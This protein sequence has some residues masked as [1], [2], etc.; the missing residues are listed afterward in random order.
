MSGLSLFIKGYSLWLMLPAALLV[1][2]LI[3]RL[4]RR[5]TEGLL[6]AGARLRTLRAAAVTLMVLLLAQPIVNSVRLEHE[7]PVVIVLRDTSTSMTVKD[8]HEPVE[9]RVRNAVALGLLDKKLRDTSADDA[10][11][12]FTQA[13]A[14]AESASGNIRQ[15][16]QLLA[17]NAAN[18]AT[19]R[20]RIRGACTS[21]GEA[22]TELQRGA[23][24]LK[25]IP[26]APTAL[27][28]GAEAQAQAIEKLAKEAGEIEAEK[29]DSQAK[30][31]D[32]A[33]VLSAL[34]PEITKLAA[35][36]QRVQDAADRALAASNN[37][38]V[39]AALERLS[40]MDRSAVVSGMIDSKAA[41]EFGDRVKLVQYGFDTDLRELAA[42][43]TS[44]DS[45]A[46]TATPTDTDLATPLI[47]IAERH[48]QDSIAAVV[49]CTDGRHTSGPI[50]ED[51]ARL[52][53]AR[54]IIVHTLGVG[55]ESAP[56]DICI[57]RL[58]GTQSV[59]MDETIKLTAHVKVAGLKGQKCNL[60]LSRE[61]KTVQ[62]RELTLGDDGWLH[63]NFE[64][65]ADKPGPNVFTASIKPLTGEALT[66]N[67]S[68]E[69]IVDVAND[70]LKVLLAD[71]LPRWESRY[72]AS[73]LRRER[74]M[75]LD[76]RW[77]LSGENLG[78]K[79]KALPQDEKALEDYEIIILGDIPAERLSEADQKRLAAYVADR[80]GFLVLLAGPRSMPQSYLTG[81]IA[82]LL[83]IRQQ[84]PASMT[85]A[86]TSATASERVRV[87][88]DEAGA[89]HEITR[90][91]H[92][93]TLNEQLWT[94]LPELHWVARPAYAKPLATT[95]L[96]TDDA[97][98]DVVVA[99]Q[100]YG[101]GRVMYVGTDG[102][103][104]WRYKVA[105]RVHAFFWSQAM[106]WGTSNRLIG[107]PRLKVGCVR[108]QIRPGE[109]VEILAR[110]RDAQ[111]HIVAD[112]TV[113][114]DLGD[115]A[116][117][118]HV[119]LT[120]VPDSG[121]LYR[122]DLQNV[123]AGVHNIV[124][125]VDA[126][127]FDGIQQEIQVIARDLAGQ[128]GIE[129]SRDSARLAAMAKAGGGRYMDILDAPELF[130]QLAGQGKERSVEK[131]YEIWSS[132]PILMLIVGLLAMEWIM[133]KRLGLA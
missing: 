66:M 54:G 80:G 5:E 35:E 20:E 19:A 111:G 42:N 76:E 94:A 51:A 24:L 116:H 60:V 103:W 128:E 31:A 105:D 84:A 85:S 79:P 90:I 43:A 62:Q 36:S 92:D 46:K 99:I 7:K 26:A 101:A 112:A 48:A 78:P 9:R 121:G 133:R 10:G 11:K 123:G 38:A 17:E 16:A 52:L 28:Q 59:F 6:K 50:P 107:G 32:K 86:L 37:P 98:K 96:S 122:G 14:A 77:L 106:R 70:R 114:A 100:N 57:A 82:D 41:A 8:V 1:A 132:Y 44:K 27:A 75:T 4:Y 64:I 73:L 118:Q 55:S 72:V 61:D 2:Y 124:V 34:P 81:P 18:S 12:A 39:T 56:P 40:T 69:C 30:L 45:A 115:P 63:E 83:P 87:K 93:P 53:A 3:T 131:S 130:S 15:A 58:E 88:L 67:N 13:A 117:P 125:K 110:P 119:Q 71:E 89:T 68:A 104:N 109:N 25:A 33:K 23:K 47:H 108:R 49:V 126:P 74:K 113:T 21:L 29:A 22:Q 97:R 65:P 91:L 120:A 129:L 127:G 102:T 95:L